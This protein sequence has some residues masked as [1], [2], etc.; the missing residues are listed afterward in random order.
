MKSQSMM[1]CSNVKRLVRDCPLCDTPC[2]SSIHPH[3]RENWHLTTCRNCSFV[4]LRDPVDY[5]QLIDDYSFDKTYW[6]E[7]ERRSKEEPIITMI[8]SVIKITRRRL[9]K[10]EKLKRRVTAYIPRGKII[11]IGCGNGQAMLK[12]ITREHE[13]WGI[14]ISREHA[15]LANAVFEAYGGKCLQADTLTGL[16]SLPGQSFNGIVMRSYLEHEINPKAVLLAANSALIPDGCVIIKVPNYA[17]WNRKFRGNKWCGYRF[18]D[19]VNYFTPASLV[20]LVKECNF[21]VA[22]FNLLDRIPTSD[23]MWMVIQKN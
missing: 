8:S 4:Y 9:S 15:R 22:K 5:E 10:R 21:S 6:A 2:N 14:D 16:T 11:D 12:W 20:S 1:S 17:S 13:P 19:H 23:N 7:K 18:P 3:N